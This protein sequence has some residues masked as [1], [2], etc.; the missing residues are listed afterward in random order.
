MEAQSNRT[1]QGKGWEKRGYHGIEYGVSH[2]IVLALEHCW[3]VSIF[4]WCT[5]Q[6]IVSRRQ[7][8]QYNNVFQVQLIHKCWF[9]VG[10][11]DKALHWGFCCVPH[12]SL[13]WVLLWSTQPVG[14]LLGMGFGQSPIWPT[15]DVIQVATSLFR[16][17]LW[18]KCWGSYHWCHCN[19][20]QH[21]EKGKEETAQAL[22]EP[23]AQL[24]VSPTEFF[25]SLEGCQEANTRAWSSFGVE[26]AHTALII[27]G[28]KHCFW[29]VQL[30]V[31]LG[32]TLHS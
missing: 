2:A 20:L 5:Q 4:F 24:L 9:Q 7:M 8:F 31:I 21:F 6:T 28:V 1:P 32:S 16:W 17:M 22:M 19:C 26:A 12:S 23:S 27:R 11:Q 25:M 18:Q 3:I 13:H 15:T 10:V 29:L 14:P 30:L